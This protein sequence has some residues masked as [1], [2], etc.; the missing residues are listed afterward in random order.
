[1]ENGQIAVL[2]GD[3][4]ARMCRHVF[5]HQM[6]EGVSGGHN[7]NAAPVGAAYFIEHG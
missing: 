5:P 2:F 4:T 6:A 3:V 1:M 7:R